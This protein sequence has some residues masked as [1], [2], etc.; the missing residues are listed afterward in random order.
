MDNLTT[1]IS[2]RTRCSWYA[3]V[4]EINPRPMELKD[5][6]LKIKVHKEYP[7]YEPMA[8]IE[9]QVE[10]LLTKE[11]GL[12]TF[13]DTDE[14]TE[15]SSLTGYEWRPVSRIIDMAIQ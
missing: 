3:G 9:I 13:L 15:V 14:F 4:Y 2:P 1:T 11:G 7:M 10:N 5:I 12:F 8:K 6:T